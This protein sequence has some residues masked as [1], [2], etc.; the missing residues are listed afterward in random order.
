MQSARCITIT[1]PPAPG[2]FRKTFDQLDH[3]MLRR[4]VWSGWRETSRLV[5]DSIRGSVLR[6]GWTDPVKARISCAAAISTRWSACTRPC[7]TTTSTTPA[8]ALPSGMT[9]SSTDLG[10]DV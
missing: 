9:R 6:D 10:R 7:S 4:E 1:S 8:I 3:K 2:L 5:R